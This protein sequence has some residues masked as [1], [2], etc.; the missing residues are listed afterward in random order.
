[1]QARFALE[2]AAVENGLRPHLS[3]RDDAG[4]V[5]P[6]EVV[7]AMI[8]GE[9]AP[10][11]FGPGGAQQAGSAGG[12]MGLGGGLAL[13]SGLIDKAVLGLLGVLSLGMMFV[14]VR[15]AARR[16]E[17]PSAEELVGLPPTLEAQSDVIGEA[18]EGETAMAGIEVGEDEVRVQKMLEQVTDYVSK[19]PDTAAKLVGRWLKSEE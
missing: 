17:L 9:G 14:M 15:R 6:G 7:V 16:V 2:R 13:G 8:P 5:I 4:E 18:D 10:A 1:M 11:G 12:V 19:N 3:L